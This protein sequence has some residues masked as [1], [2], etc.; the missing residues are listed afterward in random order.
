[1]EDNGC[2]S[3]HGLHTYTTDGT[4]LQLQDTQQKQNIVLFLVVLNT[5]TIFVQN[6]NVI[7]DM[8]ELINRNIETF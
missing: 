5:I 2:K 8:P 4:C 6:R 1:M 7:H 3:W